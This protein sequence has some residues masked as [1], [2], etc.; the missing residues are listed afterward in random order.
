[1][2]IGS[3]C[4]AW[5]RFVGSGPVSF[6][7]RADLDVVTGLSPNKALQPTRSVGSTVSRPPLTRGAVRPCC[8][9]RNMLYLARD[10]IIPTQGAAE[11]L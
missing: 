3:H 8:V 9:V 1:M 6:Q 7:Q 4:S 11:V 2:I 10:P 5:E